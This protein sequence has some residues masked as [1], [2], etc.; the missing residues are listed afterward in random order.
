MQGA[1]VGCPDCPPQCYCGESS[2]TGSGQGSCKVRGARC[3][4]AV[5]RHRC[6]PCLRQHIRPVSL[7]QTDESQ[8][9]R[10][11]V[12]REARVRAFDALWRTT[13]RH[14]LF[15]RGS[16]AALPHS[17]LRK[18]VRR[19]R[20]PGEPEVRDGRA[21][22]RRAAAVPHH[23]CVPSYCEHQL[24][25][26]LAHSRPFS[27]GC[28][29]QTLHHCGAVCQGHSGRC[30]QASEEGVFPPQILD[31]CLHETAPTR[32]GG[33]PYS[34]ESYVVELVGCISIRKRAMLLGW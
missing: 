27:A 13:G 4:G 31:R 32:L 22:E 19:H 17:L 1:W 34:Q 21:Q 5:C 12:L 25:K 30:G 23:Y 29:C 7:R 14:H 6:S 18:Q 2:Q 33:R 24:E 9:L 16:R 15:Q 11:P 20:V 26:E 28:S 3:D 8:L 10:V